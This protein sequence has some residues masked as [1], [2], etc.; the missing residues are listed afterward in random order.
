MEQLWINPIKG[1]TPVKDSDLSTGFTEILSQI[2]SH[3]GIPIDRLT[4]P[5]IQKKSHSKNR[6]PVKHGNWWE[7]CRKGR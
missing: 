5:P 7:T 3:S 1:K 6:G 2:S 4:V